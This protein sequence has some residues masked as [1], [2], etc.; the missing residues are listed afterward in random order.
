MIFLHIVLVIKFVP[1]PTGGLFKSPSLGG[2]VARAN[3]P[4]V[5]IIKLTQSN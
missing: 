1:L 4:R 3:A 5:S 2:S